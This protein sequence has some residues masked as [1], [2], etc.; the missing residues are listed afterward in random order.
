MTRFGLSQLLLTSKKAGLRS[1]VKKEG[2]FQIQRK[3]MLEKVFKA[4][5]V[6]QEPVLHMY[7]G[8]FKQVML[9]KYCIKM[10][11]CQK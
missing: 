1:W 4:C 8:V 3:L 2:P 10:Y 9:K 6:D 5:Q 11:A 7:D